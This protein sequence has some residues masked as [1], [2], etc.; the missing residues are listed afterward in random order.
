MTFSTPVNPSTLSTFP[1]MLACH[2]FWLPKAGN[3]S[4]EYEDAFWPREDRLDAAGPVRLAVADGATETSFS[5]LWARLLVS[6]YGR[7]R[8]AVEKSEQEL[9]RLRRAWKRAVG[10]KP[11][12]WY[13]E[14]KLRAGAFSSLL[15]VTLLPPAS[16]TAAGADWRATAIG[17]SCLLQVR[18]GDLIRSFPFSQADEFNSRPRLVSSLDGDDADFEANTVSGSW[19]AGDVF[20]LMTDA[21][22][23]WC[24]RA[25]ESNEPVFDR[26]NALE[27]QSKFETLVAELRSTNDADRKP[28]LKNDDVTLVRCTIHDL[29]HST[30][31]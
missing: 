13:A 14:E 25:V 12:P 29:A 5:G 15:G 18:E 4:A 6:A 22:A 27:T 11:L 19:Q 10:H 28:F 30:G 20:Y 1:A 7:G 8:L 26:L 2:V 21:L 16:P 23:C 9:R 31:L 3:T 24:L 17:D